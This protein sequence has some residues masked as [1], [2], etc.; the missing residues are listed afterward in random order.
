MP[1][2]DA[3]LLIRH[4]SFEELETVVDIGVRM[5]AFATMFYQLYLDGRILE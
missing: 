4:L 5:N 1:Y 2:P 3:Y